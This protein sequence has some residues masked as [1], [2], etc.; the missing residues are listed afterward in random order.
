MATT[1]VSGHGYRIHNQ[2]GLRRHAE[3]GF[4]ERDG[5]QDAGGCANDAGDE[6]EHC[7]FG[8][9]ETQDAAGGA[10]DRFHQADVV[11][12]LHRDVGHGGHDAERGEDEDDGDGGGEQ[13]A[14]AVVD[15]AFGFGE[16]ADAVDVGFGE[17]S[18]QSR[19]CSR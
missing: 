19:R 9:E 13:A 2:A 1:I 10:A 16:L 17:A 6:T 5:E 7:R 8:E 3:D 14:D 15:F 12:A 18:V 11:L 4:A